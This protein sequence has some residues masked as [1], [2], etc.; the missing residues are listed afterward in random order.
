M[1]F[2]DLNGENIDFTN[3]DATQKCAKL[4][5]S[6]IDS[7]VELGRAIAIK[8]LENYNDIPDTYLS[9][10]N[11]IIEAAGF[12]PYLVKEKIQCNSLH[13]QIRT[14][15]YQSEYRNEI[16]YHEEQ[17][18]I[19]DLL[20]ERKNVIV[21][22]PTSFGKSL[23]IEE[24]VASGIYKNIVIIQPTLALL[25]ETRKKLKKYL[26][27]YKIIVR[28]SQ[29]PAERNI[30]LFTAE[31]VMEYSAFHDI[32]FLVID[33]FYKLSSKRDDERSDSLNN[34]FC[35]LYYLYKPQFYL[36]GPNIDKISKAFLEK[37][38]AVFYRTNF[39]LVLNE[40][41][42]LYTAN[43]DKFGCRG[44]K[45]EFKENV[46]FNLLLDLNNEQTIVF[47]SSP[48]KAKKLSKKFS[49]FLNNSGILPVDEE[50]PLNEWIRSNINPNWS[51]IDTI[52]YKIGVHDGSLPKHI[53]GSMID[54]F[55]SGKL[56]YLFCTTTIIEGVNTT[57]KNIVYF[58]NTKGL[59]QP[60]DYFDYCNIKGRAGR[61]MIHYTGR[62][63]N[64]N[65]IPQ[66]EIIEV[67]IPF[68]DQNPI[69]DEVLI[70]LERNDVQ[71]QWKVKY[72]SFDEIP[73]ELKSIIKRNGVSIE[74]QLKIYKDIY[75][76]FDTNYKY[77]C[78]SGYPSYEQLKFIFN[79]AWNNLIKNGET[80]SPMTCPKLIK[81][82]FDYGINKSI[83]VLISDSYKYKRKTLSNPSNEEI[84][85]LCIAETYQI[86]KHWF[87]YKVPKWLSVINSIQHY[88]CSNKGCSPGD[89]SFYSNE[90]ENEF[91]PHNLNILMEYGI[92]NS[93]IKK[94][95]NNIPS[96]IKDEEIIRY[97]DKHKLYMLDDLI[98]Y[99]REKII[100]NLY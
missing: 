62:V 48:H 15:Y 31:R 43:A 10:W 34:A 66:K 95:A 7:E 94:M 89:Y 98:K 3:F 44:K 26:N 59:S 99:E 37:Y 23:L 84:L 100:E 96:D 75:S 56:S 72:D 93:A 67:D 81:M 52:N 20:Q 17:K 77:I 9:I 30:Y 22:A 70:N 58:D 50:L 64:F 11:D 83:K 73:S 5:R 38:N 21:S 1:N 19:L 13:S 85:D 49:V 76:D 90:I 36:L 18:G 2:T 80:T 42:D 88:V 29:E 82:T 24:M 86:L 41:I 55:N 69:S 74:G 63:F 47:C 12:Y 45:L 28:T 78:W 8:A 40:S 79:L 4:L 92:P 71:E 91:I 54:Y 60:I 27:S 46:L 25:D 16:F 68:F 14:N 53:T 87:S 61:M 97:I 32:E 33:E 57:S 35:K 39:T 6:N 65:P 51:L